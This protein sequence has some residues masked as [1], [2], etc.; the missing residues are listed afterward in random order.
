MRVIKYNFIWTIMLMATAVF[1]QKHTKNINES[2]NVNSDVLVEIDTRYSDIT[3][4][5]W[6]KNMVSITGVWEVEGMTEEASEKY[7]KNWTLE[8][9]G[10]KNK[11]VITSK[12]KD[13]YYVYGDVFDADHF[14]YAPV[15]AGIVSSDIMKDL[16][17]LPVM[18]PMPPLP[19]MPPVNVPV[20]A[21]LKEL[22][23]DYE[24]YQEDKEAYVKDFEKRQK[25]WEKEFE[26]RFEP[27]MKAYEKTMKEWELKMA[28]KLKEWEDEIAPKMEEW[29]IKM[30]KKMEKMEKE[31]EL[32]YAD[33]MKGK[34]VQNEE[35]Y[36]IKKR[37]LIKIPNK[38]SLK[39]DARYG[40]ISIPDNIKIVN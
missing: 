7:F 26:E 34:V 29:E 10:N 18:S 8:A 24:A 27:Q 5:I 9:L 19:P 3:V 20:L 14:N 11:V 22:E 21:Q 28:P 25:E 6:N 4:E 2:F 1:G 15:I 30:E 16:P 31:I 37:I 23:F 39:M 40:K 13:N 38:A 35:K 17:P 33:K 36:N 12:S 32:K